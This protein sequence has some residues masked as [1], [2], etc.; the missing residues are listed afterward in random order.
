MGN[1]LF[2]VSLFQK[3]TGSVQTVDPNRDPTVSCPVS[4][5][6]LVKRKR[7]RLKNRKRRTN[8]KRR[9]LRRRR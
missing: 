3:V 6:R 4:A 2:S 1:T 5:P 9:S 7:T 8:Q